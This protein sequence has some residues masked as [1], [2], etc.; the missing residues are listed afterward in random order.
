LDKRELGTSSIPVSVVGLGC[1]PL[2]GGPGWGDIAEKQAIATIHAAL[3]HGITFFDT[4]EGYNAGNSERV[5]GRALRGRRD[6]AVIAT[7]I[8]PSNTAPDTLRSH[9]EESLERLQTHWIDLYQVHWPIP[10]ERVPVALATL[11]ELQA[12]GKIRSIGISNHGVSQMQ[13]ILEQDVPIASNQLAYNLL[14]RAIEFEILPLCQRHG[15]SIIPYMPLMQGLLAGRY[16][17]ADDVPP[18]RARSRHFSSDRPEARHGEPGAEQETFEAIA[19]IR[20]IAQD[21][22][23]PMAQLSIAWLLRRPGVATVIAGARESW[24]IEANVAAANLELPPDTIEAL[25]R[26]TE[27]LRRRMG[28]NADI[29]QGG[30]NRRTQ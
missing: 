9:C 7:K 6:K 2:G 13:T 10:D 18:F 8:S 5:L 23:V 24:Q 21:M 14:C 15:I 30:E 12:E 28:P 19:A 26:A 16:E 20:E 22:G 17:R 29:W 1:W 25:D 27:A 11:A 4:A 3:D